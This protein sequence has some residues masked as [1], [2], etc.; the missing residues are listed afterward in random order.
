MIWL[1]LGYVLSY[2]IENIYEYEYE[3]EGGVIFKSLRRISLAVTVRKKT[4]LG[5]ALFAFSCHREGWFF[6]FFLNDNWW[7][8]ILRAYP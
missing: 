8:G 7:F 2:L 6:V 1:S 5:G 3:Y 4:I